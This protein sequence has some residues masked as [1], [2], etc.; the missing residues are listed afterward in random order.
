MYFELYD[1]NGTYGVFELTPNIS[2]KELQ[3]LVDNYKKT[4]EEEY[5]VDDLQ[6]FLSKKGFHTKNIEPIGIFF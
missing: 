2:R 1:D 4:D 6:K 3:K 5:N